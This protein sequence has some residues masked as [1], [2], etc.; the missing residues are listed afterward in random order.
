MNTFNFLVIGDSCIDEYKFGTIKKQNPEAPVPL[1][2]NSKK[3]YKLG[4]AINVANNLMSLGS[5][6]KIECPEPTI[7]KIRYIDERT[8]TQVFRE[9]YDFKYEPYVINS[10]YEFD[11]IVISD[12]NK[13]FISNSSVQQ[14][15]SIFK[16]PIFVDT[17]KKE[18]NT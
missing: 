16:G 4:M 3:E 17:K 18:R 5:N 15:S 7:K 13:G 2:V 12:Y 11:C 8:Q 1:F 9:D 6:V 10:N 14:I